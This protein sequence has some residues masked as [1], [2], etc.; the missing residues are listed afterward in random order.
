VR[1][2]LSPG[3]YREDDSVLRNSVEPRFNAVDAATRYSDATGFGWLDEGKREAV[4]IPLAPHAEMK[5][6]AKD[7]KNLPHDVLYRDY[8]RGSGA[9]KFGVKLPD[10]EYKVS[11]L[12]PDR[13]VDE[14]SLRTENGLLAVTTPT[15]DWS[16]SGIVVKGSGTE[17]RYP[18]PYPAESKAPYPIVRHT[19]PATAK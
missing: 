6:V 15:G 7:P 14:Q 9:Q 11:L 18:A 5:A 10:G 1:R 2:R 19:P 12:H 8:I 17:K 4:G 13:S 3:A 16:I